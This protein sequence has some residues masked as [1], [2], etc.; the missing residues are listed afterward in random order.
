MKLNYTHFRNLKCG[1]NVTLAYTIE[2]HPLFGFNGAVQVRLGIS[3][4]A[5][6]D[7]FVKAKG[8]MI[9][10]GRYAKRPWFGTFPSNDK[11]A[12]LEALFHEITG[13]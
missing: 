4:C 12:I 3:I 10:E 8:R 11:K 5:P 9:A 13:E 7:E 1:R 6:G 2:P